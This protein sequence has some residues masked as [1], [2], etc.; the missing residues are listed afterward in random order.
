MERGTV[1]HRWIDLLRGIAVL[2]M[3]WTHSA[4]AFLNDASQRTQLFQG[5][6]YYHGLVAPLFFWVAGYL[7]GLS[8]ARPGPRKPAGPTVKR[9]LGLL[10]LGYLL[11]FPLTQL[12]QGD[13]STPVLQTLFQSDVLHALSLSCLMLLAVEASGLSKPARLSWALFFG[14]AAL[15]TTQ[16]MPQL[17][18]G[19]L[20]LD[21][22]VS[23][24][25][26]S[27]FPLCPWMAFACAGFIIG[28]SGTMSWK[29]F[30]VSALGAFA[31]P[32]VPKHPDAISFFFERLGWVGMFAVLVM[33]GQE[34]AS[35][36]WLRLVGRQSLCVYVVHLLMIYRTPLGRILGRNQQWPNVIGLFF[37]LALTSFACAW[38]ID[39]W[40]DQARP[41]S[42]T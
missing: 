12:L 31:L 37:G 42:S 40:Q 29:L 35:P 15:L 2:G 28:L 38:A 34:L 16:F 27:L 9:L 23:P 1:R 6:T 21:E 10:A 19:F 22:L 26:G 33:K 41:S 17:K 5:L 18:M 20:P 4:N 25:S 13:F 7:R 8:A 30:F 39:R 11:H 14:L 3:I 32:H 36:P 24:N